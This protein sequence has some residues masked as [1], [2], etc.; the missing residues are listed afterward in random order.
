MALSYARHLTQQENVLFVDFGF[1]KIS[2]CLASV[3]N[4]S[5]EIIYES[6]LQNMGIRNMDWILCEYYCQLL[7][8]QTGEDPHSDRKVRIKL[9]KAIEK[10]RK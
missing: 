7:E 2:L 10:Q 8:K 5:V 6:Y 4:K 9:L 1:S 3:L